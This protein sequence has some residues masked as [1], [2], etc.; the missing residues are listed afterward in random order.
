MIAMAALSELRAGVMRFGTIASPPHSPLPP[1]AARPQ[2]ACGGRVDEGALVHIVD[3]DDSVRQRLAPVLEGAGVAARMYSGIA[4]FLDSERPDVP[5]CL[6]IDADVEPGEERGEDSSLHDLRP[7]LPIVVMAGRTD[8]PFAVCAMKAGVVD[9]LRMTGPEENLLAAI[10]AAIVVDREWRAA[11]A[12][13]AELRA[14]FKTL[15]RREREVMALVT[16][17]KP[18]KQVASDLG[19]SEITVKAHRGVVMR[20]MGAR[21]LPDL[22]R[23]ADGLP[24]LAQETG[25]EVPAPAFRR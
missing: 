21:S 20:K 12:V 17:G 19:V 6:V 11:V 16:D 5:G 8:V 9:F 25:R 18:N 14:R 23:M 24:E 15:T 4:A 3:V 22:V 10:H 2:A 13:Q 7:G 1:I